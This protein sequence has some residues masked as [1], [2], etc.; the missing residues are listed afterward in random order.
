MGKQQKIR[1]FRRVVKSK[2]NRTLKKFFTA[3]PKNVFDYSHLVL[4]ISALALSIV[5]LHHTCKVSKLSDQREAKKELREAWKF[6]GGGSYLEV[7]FEFEKDKTKLGEALKHIK[8][9]ESYAISD[10]SRFIRGIYC[11]ANNRLEL[12]IKYFTESI[13]S[14]PRKHEVFNS[15]GVCYHKMKKFNQAKTNYFQA[16]N[17]YP[18]YSIAYYNLGVLSLE[19]GRIDEALNY[20]TKCININ[21]Q[22]YRAFYLRGSIHERKGRYKES[23]HDYKKSLE[24]D[25]ENVLSLC[26]LAHLRL[27]IGD[28]VEFLTYQK[29]IAHIDKAIF[30]MP[31]MA[32]LYYYKACLLYEAD[33]LDSAISFFNKYLKKTQGKQGNK[34][35]INQ[36]KT[37]IDSH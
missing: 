1:S 13:N 15:R 20:F 10:H 24:I 6:L 2:K 18:K 7:N 35:W 36:A 27:L 16:L 5:A 28:Q 29:A 22:N 3:N 32:D 17:L 25:P 21:D 12:A 8:A 37:I 19:T 9:A 11:M 23:F 14:N 34:K 33:E 31:D 4:T 30:I 26:S